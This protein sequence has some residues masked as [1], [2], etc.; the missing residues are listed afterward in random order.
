MSAPPE[1]NLAEA[2][3]WLGWAREDLTL[4]EHIAADPDVV[5]RGACMWAQQAAEKAL[6]AMLIARGFD[7]P[8][9]TV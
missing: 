2:Q 7:P 5:R 9:S 4:A 3:R 1:A 6:K 8:K